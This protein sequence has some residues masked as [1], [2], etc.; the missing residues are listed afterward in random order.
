MIFISRERISK[1][2]GFESHWG[3]I[4]LHFTLFSVE[5]GMGRKFN[6]LKR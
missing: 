1:S 4:F 6:G 2:R 5:S 3:T